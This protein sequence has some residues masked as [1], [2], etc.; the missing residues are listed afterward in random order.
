[1]TSQFDPLTNSEIDDMRKELE[2]RIRIVYFQRGR[3]DFRW[4]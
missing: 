1:M 4:Y 3:W 2:R